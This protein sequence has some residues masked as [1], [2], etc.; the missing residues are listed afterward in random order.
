MR[1]FLTSF[2]AIY[3]RAKASLK[4]AMMFVYPFKNKATNIYST[5][6]S[7]L[8]RFAKARENDEKCSNDQQILIR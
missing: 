4:S 5:D 3:L 7:N 8:T 2:G 6:I 1:P